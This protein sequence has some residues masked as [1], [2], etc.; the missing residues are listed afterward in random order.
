M[1]DYVNSKIYKLISYNCDN[2]YIGSTAKKRLSDR[3]SK[4]KADYNIWIKG[5][6]TYVSSFELIK[7]DDC[8]II[9]VE[10]YPCKSRDELRSREQ[11]WIEQFEN[12]VNKNRAYCSDEYKKK[13][14]KECDK[15][16]R[17]NNKEIL[18]EKR[19]EKYIKNKEHEKEMMKKWRDN[20]RDYIKEK[21]DCE[22]G[23]V[24]TRN[25]KSKHFKTKKHVK[26]I[27]SL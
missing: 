15:K 18:S 1:V 19:K 8:K 17:Q 6:R 9:L 10:S 7:F 12:T 11:Y 23:S 2:I 26:Y 3:K 24:Y 22:C 5:E 4:H 21:F 16:Y 27:N 13:F 20:N 14:K 25:G